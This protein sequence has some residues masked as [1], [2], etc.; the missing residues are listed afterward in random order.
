MA[1]VVH[2]GDVHWYVD[3]FG[4]LLGGG[5]GDARTVEG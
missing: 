2:D 5:E 4:A 1:C 3:F